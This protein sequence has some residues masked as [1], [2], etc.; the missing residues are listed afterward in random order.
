MKNYTTP[1]KT[2]TQQ[3]GGRQVTEDGLAAH[4]ATDIEQNEGGS[5]EP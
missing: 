5:L 4:V 2:P 1:L 3:F